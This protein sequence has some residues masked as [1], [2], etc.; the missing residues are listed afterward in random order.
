MA[1]RFASALEAFDDE[2]MAAVE[3][4]KPFLGIF[5]V[6]G[7]SVATFGPMLGSETVS[8]SDERA[9]AIDELQFDLGEGPCW[10]AVASDSPVLEPDL[11]GAPR[12]TWSMFSQAVTRL[13]IGALFAFPMRVGPFA[14]GAIDLYSSTPVEL[15]S[16]EVDQAV[17]LSDR[18][19][20]HVLRAALAANEDVID[21]R[22][23]RSRRVVHQATGMVLA[24]LDVSA[25]EARLVIG[26]HAYAEGKTMMVVAQ[27]IL[28]GELGFERGRDT[29]EIM[30]RGD[31]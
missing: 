15:T 6:T 16:R 30:Q 5:P 9:A 26:G 14:L 19:G 21:E 8:A 22:N 11:V 27:E 18:V 23:P 20:K 7:A 2:S 12:R 25:E 13:D 10:D 4:S 17:E 24:Q 28:D 29:T 31:R 3:L 1:D